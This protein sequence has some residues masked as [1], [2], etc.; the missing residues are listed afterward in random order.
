M[1]LKLIALFSVLAL[2]LAACG[3][4]DDSADETTTTAAE[5]TTTTEAMEEEMEEPGTIV[6]VAV[7]AGSFSTLVTAVQE[8]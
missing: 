3:T 7:A 5:A 1:K 4:D 8:A 6:D 2:V